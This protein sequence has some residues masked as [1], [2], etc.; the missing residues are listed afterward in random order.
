M[1]SYIIFGG[2]DLKGTEY[3]GQEKICDQCGV[4]GVVGIDILSGSVS[5]HLNSKG[6]TQWICQFCFI[7]YLR[8]GISPD[9]S[10]PEHL[11]CYYCMIKS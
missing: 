10:N 5:D 7:N 6:I 3:M 2:N 8:F 4:S 11:I 9:E 1:I